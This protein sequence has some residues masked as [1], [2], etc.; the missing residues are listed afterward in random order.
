MEAINNYVNNKKKYY[1]S[2]QY[3]H[4]TDLLGTLDNSGNIIRTSLIKETTLPKKKAEGIEVNFDISDSFR[5]PSK[6]NNPNTKHKKVME[7]N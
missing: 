2:I 7:T 1:R 5:F 4:C 3:E 6:K